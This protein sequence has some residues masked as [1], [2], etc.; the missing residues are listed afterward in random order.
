[1][2]KII[3]AILILSMLLCF[4][5]C[6]KKDNKTKVEDTSAITD[7]N[8]SDTETTAKRAKGNNYEGTTR[9]EAEKCIEYAEKYL[10]CLYH[11]KTDGIENGQEIYEQNLEDLKDLLCTNTFADP[12]YLTEEQEAQ[13]LEIVKEYVDMADFSFDIE[14]NGDGTYSA[15]VDTNAIHILADTKD[16]IAAYREEWHKRYDVLTNEELEARTEEQWAADYI[17][18]TD[19]II[20]ILKNKLATIKDNTTPIPLYITLDDTT[21]SGLSMEKDEFNNYIVGITQ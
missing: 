19:S 15:V 14:D 11:A 9:E 21:E 10:N 8:G 3:S 6:G 13:Y 17:E 20:A 12:E 5:A 18:S 16:E 7:E 2:K 1:M 4:A